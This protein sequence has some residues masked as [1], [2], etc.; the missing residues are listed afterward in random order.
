MRPLGVLAGFGAGLAV[1]F[2][3]GGAGSLTFGQAQ[4][5]AKAPPPPVD[6]PAGQALVSPSQLPAVGPPPPAHLVEHAVNAGLG[7]CAPVLERMSREIIRGAYNV[8]SGWNLKDPTG[9]VFQSVAGLRNPGNKPP[10]ALAALIAAPNPLK[11]CDGVSVQVYPLSVPCSAVQETAQKGGEQIASLE[12]VR[13]ILDARK[14][15]LFLLPG[16]G[17]TC[18]V[19]SIISYFSAP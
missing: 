8:Q 3:L 19:V 10:N 12:G 11:E 5:G 14:T 4:S 1:A 9:H 7:Q 18:V 6:A 2:L 17:P 16:A 15:R 13:V